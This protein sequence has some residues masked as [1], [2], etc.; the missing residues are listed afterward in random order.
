MCGLDEMLQPAPL[1]L[2]NGK[3]AQSLLPLKVGGQFAERRQ[4]RQIF[5]LRRQA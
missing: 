5:A 2:A 3:L 1:P 4:Q